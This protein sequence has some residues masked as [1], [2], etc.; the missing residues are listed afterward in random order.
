MVQSP[1]NRDRCPCPS[2]AMVPRQGPL[3]SWTLRSRERGRL[4]GRVRFLPLVL[5]LKSTGHP[6]T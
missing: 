5:T 6:R 3:G 4:G 2:H 1:C